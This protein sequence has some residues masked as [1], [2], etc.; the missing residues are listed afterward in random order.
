MKG[1]INVPFANVRKKPDG[2][3]KRVLP[4]GTEVMIKDTEESWHK[5]NLG[6][7]RTDLISMTEDE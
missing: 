6:Y 4:Y 3:I 1:F 2:E 5:T 7:I